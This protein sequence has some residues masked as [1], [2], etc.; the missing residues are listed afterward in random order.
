MTGRVCLRCDWAGETSEGTCPLCGARLY[1]SEQTAPLRE[2]A[3]GRVEVGG[4]DQGEPPAV[5]LPRR[6]RG[7]RAVRAAAAI[8][9]LVVAATTIVAVQVHT[10]GL[11]RGSA[12][13]GTGLDGWLVY[14]DAVDASWSRIWAWNLA[15]GTVEQGPLVRD[16]LELVDASLAHPGWVGVTSALWGDRRA[17]SVLQFHEPLARSAFIRSGRLV[18]WSAGGASVTVADET[19]GVGCDR[20]LTV[21]THEFS[22]GT[23]A[24][25]YRGPACG[26]LYSMGSTLSTPY[27][28]LVQHGGATV[29]TVGLGSLHPVLE[30]HLLLSISIASDLLVVPASAFGPPPGITAA[31]R[32]GLRIFDRSPLHQR[33][34]QISA[35]GE[36]FYPEDVLAWSHDGAIAYLLGAVG[37]HDRGVYAVDVAPGNEP[38]RATREPSL[39]ATT[40]ADPVRATVAGDGRLILALDHRVYVVGTDGLEQVPVPSG[41]G[42][43]DGPLV[44]S[45]SLRYSA[46]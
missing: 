43:P 28:T 20:R 17:A 34:I 37:G 36:N 35:G 2:A 18:A 41:A 10:P 12:S 19:E 13:G 11:G 32:P 40:E 39:I 7:E 8:A 42:L 16:P 29:D 44:W 45:A 1:R 15:D 38:R 26:D 14:A 30:D 46:S 33:P 27:L 5:D 3:V 4:D 6:P 25:R 31:Q 21:W 23:S 9:L 22:L 24:I